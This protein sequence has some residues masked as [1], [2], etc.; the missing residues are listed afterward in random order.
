M[1]VGKQKRLGK[2][3]GKKKIVDPFSK[4]DWYDLK[5][6]AI[7]Q[8]RN[9]GKTPVSRTVGTKIAT[10][11]LKGRVV[12]VSLADLNKDEESSFLKMRFRVDD[13]QGKHCLTNFHGLSFTSDKLKGLVRKWQTLIEACLDLKTTDGYTLRL[14]A[15]AFTK[16]RQ[17]QIKKTSYAQSAQIR[18]IRKKMFDVMRREAST[19]TLKELWAKFSPNTIGKQIE[20]ECQGIYPL[21]DVYIRKVKLLKAPK[22]DPYKLLELHG[23]VQSSAAPAEDTGKAVE[24]AEEKKTEEAAPAAK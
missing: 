18:Q 13:I 9:I 6:P 12:E 11:A 22:F 4:K 20:K 5:A 8:N 1:A 19:V 16:R 23:E 3:G 21:K 24:R 15:L 14:F 10:D 17:N 7:F 2:K